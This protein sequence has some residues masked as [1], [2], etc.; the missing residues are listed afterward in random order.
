MS[1]WP[2]ALVAI[3][4]LITNTAAHG[5]V[6]VPDLAGTW[7]GMMEHAGEREPLALT[8]EPSAGDTMLL[9]LTEPIV[10]WDHVPLGRAVVHLNGDSVRIGPFRLAYDAA[11]RTLAG[12]M[13]RALVPVHS[14]PFVL[15]RVE[16]VDLPERAAPTAPVQEPAW[17]FDAG[18][19]LWAGPTFD[20]GLVYVGGEDGTLHALDA[21]TGARRW[22]YHCGGPL[23][24]RPALAGGALYIAADDGV[25]Y[26]LDARRGAERWHVRLSEGPVVRLP[27]DDPRSRYDRFGS[28]VTVA[29]GTLYVGTNDGKL[30]AL[31]A[32]DGRERWRFA[33]GDAVLAAPAVSGARVVFGSYDH[34][35]YALDRARGTLLWKR[36]T[37]GAVVSTPALDRNRA[38]VGTRAYE[39]LGL[40]LATGDVRWTR[41]IWG[42]WVESSVAV[43]DGVGYV[44]S[45]DAAAVY[46]F[47]MATGAPRWKADVY[48][49]SWGQPAVDAARV[50]AG[51][52]SQVGYPTPLAGGLFAIDR[53]RGAL[54]WRYAVPVPAAGPYGFAGSPALG[55]G[56][57]FA[58]GL[59][60]R[61]Y[62][63]RQDGGGARRVT[64]RG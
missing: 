26:A 49:W 44:G 3:S 13:P 20:G 34:C 62:A 8:F 15:H 5:A 17:T 54:A 28:D 19:R 24:A 43:K 9:R 4:I 41:Y 38:V 21:R 16:R 1:R 46:A 58:G 63:F 40:D 22:S 51:A 14:I 55:L 31:A 39:L 27:F 2:A 64:H 25:L 45:S 33:A 60:G 57:V 18:A 7:S 29:D 59:D 11:A 42:S 56:L 50:Y 61:V 48:G 12:E 35:V 47:D 36:D 53:A 30:V 23:R 32:A 37:Q 10:H 52:S 6:T